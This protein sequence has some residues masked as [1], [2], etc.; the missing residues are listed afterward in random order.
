MTDDEK[1]TA[2][3]LSELA[4]RAYSRGIAAYSDF[5]TLAEQSLVPQSA[6]GTEYSLF[7]GFE[8][9]ERCIACFGEDAALYAPIACVRIAPLNAKFSDELSHSDY[10]GALMHLGLRRET[11]GDIL[12]SGGNGYVFCLESV[13]D[14]IIS[15]LTRIKRTSVSAARE[16]T[17]PADALPTLKSAELVVASERLDAIA[18]AVYHLSRGE[19]QKLFVQEKV[20]INGRVCTNTSAAPHEGDVI[21]VRGHGRFVYRGIARETRKGRLRVALDIY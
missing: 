11:L 7:G 20:F 21:S 12:L 19:S 17:P 16:D 4:E 10:L 14:F 8:G 3:R 18:A 13:A 5:L 9:A 15:E 1:L 6:S 2:R